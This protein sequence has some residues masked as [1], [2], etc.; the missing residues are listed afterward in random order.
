MFR[1]NRFDICIVDESTQVIQPA[2]LGP[3]FNAHKFILVGD[4]NQLPPVIKSKT[5]RS[6]GASES[7]FERLDSINNTV[8]LKLQYRMNKTIKDLANNLTYNGELKAGCES[9]ENTTFASQDMEIPPSDEKWIKAALSPNLDDSVIIINTGCTQ[10]IGINFDHK[11]KNITTDTMYSNIW[12][13]ALILRLLK[14]LLQMG[15]NCEQ[16]GIIA[17]YKA[18]VILLKSLISKKIEI[19]TVDQYQG[20]DKAVIL[21]SCARSMKK[22]S[23]KLQDS[24]ILEDQ[25]RLTVAITR[26][27]YKLIIIA[28]KDTIIQYKPFKKLFGII[29]EKNVINLHDNVDN[30]TWESIVEFLIQNNCQ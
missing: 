7:L 16:I 23:E 13:A 28:D 14:T 11:N 1:K 3:L 15:I 25:R 20:R 12:E 6:L 9:V 22:K 27:K 18:Q 19:N 4:P 26:A 17:A 8:S 10:D 21:F 24:G 5:A 2:I 30:F 29:Q